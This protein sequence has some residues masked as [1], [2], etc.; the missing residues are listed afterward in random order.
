MIH[1]PITLENNE[2]F[3]ARGKCLIYQVVCFG[4]FIVKSNPLRNPRQ[5]R[6]CY[7]LHG[8]G[9]QGKCNPFNHV[10][11]YFHFKFKRV[12]NLVILKLL[13]NLTLS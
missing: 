11:Y 10:H 2:N 12:L 4:V 1:L 9:T 7:R 8:Y 13:L 5:N 6:N 3:A